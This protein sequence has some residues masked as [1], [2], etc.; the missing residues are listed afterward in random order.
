MKDKIS[1][2]KSTL[3]LL[4][5]GLT[6]PFAGK[7]QVLE[8]IKNSFGQYHE[9]VLQEKI[10]VHT[11]KTFYMAGEIVW[12]KVY[13]VDATSN[14]PLNV[15]K[16]A[17]VDVLDNT[18]SPLMQ[19]K[20]KLQNGIGSG[21]LYVPVTAVNGNYKMRSYTN[22]MK[23]FSPDLYFGQAISIINPLVSPQAA[24]KT[25]AAED[26]IRFFPESG[27]LVAGV[28][29]TVAFK[30]V[31]ANGKGLE[32]LSGFILNQHNDTITKFRSLKFGMGRFSFTPA[33]N[34]TYKAIIRVGQS[35][36][37]IKELPAVNAQGYVMQVSDGGAGQLAVT[38]SGTGSPNERLYVFAHS[39]Q[40]IKAAEGIT[41]NNGSARFSIDKSKLGDGITHFTLFN[42][43]K[44]PLCERLYFKRPTPLALT[45]LA[46]QPTYVQRKKVSVDITA[47][48]KAGVPQKA[49][50]S[51]AV[52]RLDS[53]ETNAPADI[54]SYL[55]LTS[56]VKG[57]IESPAYY[58][59]NTDAETT[60]AIDNLMLTQGWSRF[61][62]AN[63][64]SDK[65]PAFKFLP[66]YNGHIIAATVNDA[67]SKPAEQVI[68]Y[69]G[70]T[71]KSVQLYGAES[72]AAGRMLFNMKDFYGPN[73]LVLQFAHDRDSIY[74]MDVESPFSEQ[75]SN[76]TLPA[77]PITANIK[78]AL[79]THSIAVQAQN[80]YT[81]KQ[82][83]QYFNPQ[84]DSSAFYGKPYKTYMLDDFTRFTTMEEV[85]REYVSEVNVVHPQKHFHIKTLNETGFL[86]GDPLVLLDGVPVLDMDR[87]FAIDPLKVKRLEVVP[88]RYFY[89]PTSSEGI[90]SYTTY[91]GDFG[92]FEINPHAVVMDYE[93]LQLQR[94]F[95]Q[96]IY[97]S[98]AAVKSRLPDFRTLLYWSPDVFTDVKGKTQASF[99]TSDQTGKYIGILQGI[100]ANGEVGSRFFTF[101][102]VK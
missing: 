88:Y 98:E 83:K 18:N 85:M 80:L 76:Y 10:F 93:G 94:E 49:D 46:D 38:V 63:V 57:N 11:D 47:A 45:A 61:Q 86:S 4:S 73:E 1:Q 2:I 84:A 95:Y 31:G 15:S 54:L 37:L 77:L 72:D 12:F 53:L 19:A 48:N 67:S 34:T 20:I 71:G 92:G 24:A 40:A 3:L 21:S 99:Y 50:M 43:S 101:D 102:V 70:I 90:F 68:S 5:I 55:Y 14:K 65:K 42:A 22:F 35:G 39:G 32:D 79:E 29:T 58:L 7:A 26:D 30:A 9:Q 23:N 44:Q 97:D 8:S 82:M 16:V 6:F 33:A 75:F 69:L 66:E 100:T 62:W 28:N 56:E 91:K 87:V 36:L 60:E 13:V 74:H 81:A 27:N 96:P 51:L 64:L 89:G 17:Y 59:K 78:T 52:Y 41:L 25:K